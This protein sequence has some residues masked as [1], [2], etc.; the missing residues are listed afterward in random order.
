MINIIQR[1]YILCYMENEM[2]NRSKF[3]WQNTGELKIRY[4]GE[5]L[6]ALRFFPDDK[7]IAK[8]AKTFTIKPNSKRHMLSHPHK[9]KPN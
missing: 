6:A 4:E 9:K 5:H 7:T 1:G 3:R 8:S 2:K